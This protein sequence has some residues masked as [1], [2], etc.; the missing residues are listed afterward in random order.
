VCALSAEKQTIQLLHG[1]YCFS[2]KD[3]LLLLLVYVFVHLALLKPLKARRSANELRNWLLRWYP[4]A[5]AA[6]AWV[7]GNSF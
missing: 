2:H 7:I 4:A 5:A 6:A 3:E 1:F